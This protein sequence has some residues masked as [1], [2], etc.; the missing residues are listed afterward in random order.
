[1]DDLEPEHVASISANALQLMG[2]LDVPIIPTNFTVWFAYVLGRSAALR[3]MINI[4]RSN[5]RHFD[6]ALNRELYGTFVKSQSSFG[7][8]AETISE[9]LDAI[10]A[11]VRSDLSGAI[12]DNAAHSEELTEVGRTLRSTGDT[13]LALKRLGEELAKATQRASGLEAKLVDASKELDGLRKS[14]EEAEAR[15]RTDAL[16]GLAN[17]R[18]MEIFLRAAQLKAMEQ[19]DPLSVFLVDV[20][21]FKR[22]NDKYGHQLGDQVLRIVAKY[23]QEGIRDCDLAARYG[24]EE[25]LCILPGATIESCQQ[26]AERIRTRIASAKVT[27]RT[28]GEEVGQVTI[29]IGVALFDPGESFDGL[30]ERC[31]R[32]LY[33]AKQS[34]RNCTIIAEA[35]LG[36]G[37]QTD[38]TRHPRACDP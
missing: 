12:A 5:K 38:R 1:M 34:G 36:S 37:C 18:A 15:S 26:V 7:D 29:S 27:R 22:F 8:A 31:D 16:T 9:E 4:L 2:Q 32:A 21:H 30:I 13:Q 11:N 24:G 25:L 28:T 19:G 23:L 6:K 3:K 14:L 10:L 35:R 17:R 33:Q 20:D